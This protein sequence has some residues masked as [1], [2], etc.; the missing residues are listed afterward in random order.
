MNQKK[1]LIGNGYALYVGA[2]VDNRKHTHH[3]IQIVISHDLFQIDINSQSMTCQ[4]VIIDSEIPHR[5]HLG[6]H[7]IIV[8]LEPESLF[9]AYIRQKLTEGFLLCAE[10]EILSLIHSTRTI[11]LFSVQGLYR[12]FSYEQQAVPSMDPRIRLLLHHLSEP[13]NFSQSLEEVA[14]LVNISQSR[15]EHLFKNEVGISMKQFLL[16]QKMIAAIKLSKSF[17]RLTDVAYQC[18]FS[19]SAHLSR[20]FSSMFGVKMKNIIKNSNSVQVFFR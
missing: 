3:A 16:W 1:L 4:G 13:E 7:Y 10:N 19:D 14:N 15:I 18:G 6:L 9:G 20:C 2:L 8:L 17:K 5:V 11:E 12:V